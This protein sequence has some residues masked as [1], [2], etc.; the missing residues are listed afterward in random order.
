VETAQRIP[1][2]GRHS[3]SVRAQRGQI[4]QLHFFRVFPKC[5]NLIIKLIILVLDMKRR[6]AGVLL[7]AMALAATVKLTLFREISAIQYRELAGIA[8]AAPD[9]WKN[10]ARQALIDADYITEMKFR[11][12]VADAPTL[13][14]DAE[15]GPQAM[16]RSAARRD[17]VRSLAFDN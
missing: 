1:S 14:H 4:R 13:P 15:S 16:S 7:V 3:R 5:C 11:R 10:E 9:R 2:E 8:T 17:F 12:L 6:I